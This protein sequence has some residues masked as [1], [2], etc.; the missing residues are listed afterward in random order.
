MMW[1]ALPLLTERPL[2]GRDVSTLANNDI[3]STLQHFK[4]N[5]CDR[6]ASA[7]QITALCF[8]CFGSHHSF[9]PATNSTSVDCSTDINIAKTYVDVPHLFFNGKKNSSQH[10]VCNAHHWPIPL[11]GA[12]AV[13]PSVR[14]L[15]H[16]VH[17]AGYFK[18]VSSKSHIPSS[19]NGQKKKKKKY[20]YI[21]RALISG[22]SML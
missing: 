10:I 9:H 16:F 18:F 7:S 17:N 14:N 20:I 12:A 1:L 21:Y 2:S 6:T 3:I 4:T 5:S 11:W 13:V 22:Q 19:G 15:Y 8:P